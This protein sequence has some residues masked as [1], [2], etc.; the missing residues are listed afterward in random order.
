VWWD[1]HQYMSQFYFFLGRSSKKVITYG[2]FKMNTTEHQTPLMK[3]YPDYRA[4]KCIELVLVLYH[5]VFCPR[6][7]PNGHVLQV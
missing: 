1:V 5:E 2:T 7:F 4:F 6:S 3:V